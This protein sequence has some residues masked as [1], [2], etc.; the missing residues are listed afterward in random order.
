M[1]VIESSRRVATIQFR[2]AVAT[3][4]CL[5]SIIDRRRVSLGV[6]LLCIPVYLCS[7]YYCASPKNEF[8]IEFERHTSRA[9]TA[10]LVNVTPTLNRAANEQ[11]RVWDNSS[12]TGGNHVTCSTI[13]VFTQIAMLP[14][15]PT[16]RKDVVPKGPAQRKPVSCSPGTVVGRTVS[17]LLPHLHNTCHNEVDTADLKW[18]RRARLAVDRTPQHYLLEIDINSHI[19]WD[20][21]PRSL[22]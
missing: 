15:R 1:G 18:L 5:N 11:Q 14:R 12:P 13:L 16:V 7:R 9:S 17:H 6:C 10:T 3:L 22:A 20:V 2:P 19:C 8:A 4:S 21:R